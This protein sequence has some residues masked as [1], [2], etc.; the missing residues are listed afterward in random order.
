L[1]V[2]IHGD[3]VRWLFWLRWKIL[4]RSF[5]RGSGRVSR[6]VGTVFLVLF[7]LPFVGGIAVGTYFAYRYLPPP[8][9]TEILFLVLT[10][11]YLLWLVLPL[12]EFSVNEGLDLSKLSLFP[13]TRA[14]LMVSLLLSTLLDIPTIG[15]LLVFAAVVAGW[16]LS[17]PLALMALLTMLV[18]Y[19]QVIGMSQ[20]VLA[21]LMRVLQS[22]RFRD[23]SIIIVALFSSSCY[24]FQQLA[25]RGLGSEGFISNLNH[26]T[27]SPYLQ[28]LPPGMAARAIQQAVVGNWAMSFIWLAALLVIS[29]AVLYL[30]QLVVERGLNSPE[31]GGVQRVRRRRV[32]QAAE[33]VIHPAGFWRS[34]LASQVVAVALKDLKYFRRD[35]QLQA[36][37]AQSIVSIVVL[38]V[39]TLFNPGNNNHQLFVSSWAVMLAP[40]FVFFTLY[41]LSCNTLGLER[42]SLVTLFLFPV[43]PRRI[44]WG[45]NLVVFGIGIVEVI[46]VVSIA[47]FISRGWDMLWPAL[48]V[49]V[50]GIGVM[51]G[52]GNFTSV[53]FPQRMRLAQRGFR[54]SANMS[55]EGG[56]LR[57]VMSLAALAATAVILIPVALALIAPVYFN[58]RWLWAF[59]IPASLL[60]G[61]AFYYVVTELVA[62]RIVTKAPEI[63]EITTRE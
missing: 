2:L 23:L 6:I 36:T 7:G 10:G 29:V 46:L 33:A 41:S 48:A 30:W 62:P 57:A 15:L 18:F 63:L 39:I 55:S 38:I 52:C 16:A 4:I 21:L 49:G 17:V 25:F 37:F 11:V 32:A 42:Q 22:R 53:F 61:A 31:S 19:V 43:E 24:L 60:Y 8:A 12:L 27:V 35:P 45:K 20:L 28:W 1:F 54:A 26:T 40:L 50:A 56:C 59:S 5:T 47:T 51:L 14:E 34:A 9:N 13:L 3:K 58:L 44:L